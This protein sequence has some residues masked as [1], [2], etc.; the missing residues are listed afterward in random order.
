MNKRVLVPTDFSKNALNALRYATSLYKDVETDFFLMNAFQAEGYSLDSMQ[1]PEPGESKYEE[2]KAES[3]RGME[4]LMEI[5]RL[6]PENPNHSFHTISSFNSLRTA[7]RYFIDKKDIDIVVMGTKGIT[8]SAKFILGTNAVDLMEKITSCPVLAIPSDYFFEPINEIVFPTDY[9]SNFKHREL[10]HLIEIAKLHNSE[11]CVLHVANEKNLSKKQEDNKVLLED[12][13]EGLNVSIHTMSKGDKNETIITF[14]ESRKSDLLAFLNKKHWF[15][16]SI[17][18][19]P[20]VKEIGF[21]GHVPML[22]MNDK[23]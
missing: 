15:F 19:N 23:T 2:A 18:S 21:K 16:G 1:V 6:H 11:I 22:V 5:L 9:K 4:R 13:F 3:D 14:V 17:L 20:L 12:I 10:D 8:D 7:T